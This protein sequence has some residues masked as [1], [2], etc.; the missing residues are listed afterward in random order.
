MSVV[1]DP[2]G[3]PRILGREDVALSLSHD[4]GWWR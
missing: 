4:E 2:S 3:A 1:N